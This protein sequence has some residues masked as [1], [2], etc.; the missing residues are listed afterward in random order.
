MSLFNI[1]DMRTN[2]FNP[3]CDVVFEVFSDDWTQE[4]LPASTEDFTEWL[5]ET[6]IYDSV[7]IA[8][9]F[10][11]SVTMYLYD[12]GK[13]KTDHNYIAAIH[14]K[15]KKKQLTT[16]TYNSKLLRSF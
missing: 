13:V 16:W 4:N 12:P 7:R 6:S 8:M 14:T 2:E 5:T 1:V 10:A 9:R 3:L 15:L 11:G